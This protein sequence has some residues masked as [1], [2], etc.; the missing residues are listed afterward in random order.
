MGKR[1]RLDEPSLDLVARKVLMSS[2]LYYS[3]G[4]PV[5]NDAQ[6]DAWCRRLAKEWD[7]LDRYRQWQLGSAEEIRHSGFH[8]KVTEAT[9]GGARSWLK[10]SGHPELFNLEYHTPPKFSKRYQVKWWAPESFTS[11]P[12]TPPPSKKRVRLSDTPTKK[13][14]RL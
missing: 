7:D 2:F 12:V 9:I 8:V 5:V 11:V 4:R 10:Y 13:R 3:L 1:V 6:F 14:V